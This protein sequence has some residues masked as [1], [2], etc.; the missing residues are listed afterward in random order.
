MNSK[1]VDEW[2]VDFMKL[3]D[4]TKMKFRN[5]ELNYNSAKNR[6]YE[7]GNDVRHK[8]QLNDSLSTDEKNTFIDE[9]SDIIVEITTTWVRNANETMKVMTTS[10]PCDTL[11]IFNPKDLE[12]CLKQSP[13]W[14]FEKK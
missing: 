8:V 12:K 4:E 13:S 11:F 9:M 1:L 6:L 5:N 7:I 2:R 14:S 3:V 10:S